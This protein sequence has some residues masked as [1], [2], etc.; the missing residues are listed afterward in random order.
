LKRLL[1]SSIRIYRA[2][3]EY[4]GDMKKNIYKFKELDM[5]S[6]GD[7]IFCLGLACGFQCANLGYITRKDILIQL[8]RAC[9]AILGWSVL[10]GMGI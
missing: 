7:G 5:E 6:F 9:R 2:R 8:V 4:L 1:Q 10:A 3:N